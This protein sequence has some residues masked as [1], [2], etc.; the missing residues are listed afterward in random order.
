M[1][2]DSGTDYVD[3]HSPPATGTQVRV[4]LQTVRTAIKRHKNAGI[5]AAVYTY[6]RAVRALGRKK[7]RTEEIADAL[8][9]PIEDVNR[10]VSSLRR[11]GVRVVGV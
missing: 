6:I 10:A 2:N 7:L 1:T 5:E 3:L 9:L 8:A 11:R 4:P